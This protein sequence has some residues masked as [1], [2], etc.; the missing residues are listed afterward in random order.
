MVKTGRLSTSR[1]DSARAVPEI[2]IS[3]IR[4]K[5]E[6]RLKVKDEQKNT[7][8]TALTYVEIVELL[9][10]SLDFRLID[11]LVVQRG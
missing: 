4:I 6:L 3:S 9:R 8:T 7:V 1:T 2:Q 10:E 5:S 11:S